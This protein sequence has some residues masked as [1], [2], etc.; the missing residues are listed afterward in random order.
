MRKFSQPPHKK[1][2]VSTVYAR[3]C[4]CMRASFSHREVCFSKQSKMSSTTTKADMLKEYE[5]ENLIKFLRKDPK[6]KRIEVGDLFT[7]LE[8]KK[9]P[10][11]YSSS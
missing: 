8:K 5:T 11:I 3:S 9:S 7:K 4:V 2:K 10:V 1:I 6:L